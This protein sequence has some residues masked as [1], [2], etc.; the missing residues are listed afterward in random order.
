MGMGAVAP[1]PAP[2]PMMEPPQPQGNGVSGLW[3]GMGWN[4]GC[5]PVDE[6]AGSMAPTNCLAMPARMNAYGRGGIAKGNA[7]EG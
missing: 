3:D 6:P 7:L 4:R 2:I 1:A 5:L